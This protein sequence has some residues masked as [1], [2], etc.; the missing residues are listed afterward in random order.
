MPETNAIKKEVIYK[1]LIIDDNASNVLLLE[2]MLKING[3]NDI[4]TSTDARDTVELCKTY[5][6]DL[7]LLDFRM[8]YLDGFEV[9]NALHAINIH[10]IPI[11]MISA[12]NDKVYYE[13]ALQHGAKDF[14]TKPFNF[15][16]ALLK[17]KRCLYEN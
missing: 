8:P 7:L 6:P 17:I 9:I 5:I 4:R 3:Y 16:E 14:I 12:E 13:K 11:I 1:I 2:K 15:S 10:T